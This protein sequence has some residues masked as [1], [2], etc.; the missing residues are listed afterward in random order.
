MVFPNL[1]DAREPRKSPLRCAVFLIFIN[2]VVLCVNAPQHRGSIF[3]F[4]AYTFISFKSRLLSAPF[5]Y[6][7]D[8]NFNNT[9]LILNI[10]RESQVVQLKVT[11][12]FLRNVYSKFGN[13]IVIADIMAQI[14]MR[15]NKEIGH[16]F[17]CV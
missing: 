7:I 15:T 10:L 5:R 2:T 17:I 16:F 4:C 11:C 1:K 3:Y 13:C 8:F 14:R 12:P 6:K 9:I